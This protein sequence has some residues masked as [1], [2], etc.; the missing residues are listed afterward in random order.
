MNLPHISLEDAQTK[1][2][3]VTS[4]ESLMNRTKKDFGKF[5]Q[6]R[7]NR[8]RSYKRMLESVGLKMDPILLDIISS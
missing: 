2:K 3:E 8:L 1:E 7:L 4:L 6:N 5:E